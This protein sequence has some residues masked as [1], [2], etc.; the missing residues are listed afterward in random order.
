MPEIIYRVN[1]TQ[2][3]APL[4]FSA[5]FVAIGIAIMAVAL[6]PL[7]ASAHLAPGERS[8]G[9]CMGALFAVAGLLSQCR[10]DPPTLVARFLL[11]ILLSMFAWTFGWVGLGPGTR[12]FSSSVSAFGVT[13]HASS[14]ATPGRIAFGTFGVIVA[15]FA[16]AAW[17]SLAKALVATLRARGAQ[18]ASTSP[19]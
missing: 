9:V 10:R 17:W 11:A 7:P 2:R 12:S 6:R 13:T 14:G 8:V 5:L 18:E 15:L 16:A 1:T 19:E 3:Q 4:W